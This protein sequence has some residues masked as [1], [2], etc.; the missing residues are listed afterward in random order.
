MPRPVAPRA[1]AAATIALAIAGALCGAIV[2]A[3]TRAHAYEAEID[4]TSAGQAYQLKGASGE[5][6]LSR[7]RVTQ[8]LSLGIYDIGDTARDGQGPQISF[9][10][11]LR[12]DADFGMSIE[13]YALDRTSATARFVP[14]LAP[15]PIDL[16]YGYLEARRLAGGRITARL[17]RQYVVDP[18]GFYSF[19]GALMRLLTPVYVVVEAYGG[20]E[21]RGGLPLSSA[22][23]EQGVQRLDRAGYPSTGYPSYQQAAIA[24]VYAVALESA[25]PTWIH[26][27]LSYRKAWNTGESFVGNNGFLGGPDSLGIYDQRRVSSERLGFGAEAQPL[28]LVDLR[29]SVVYDLYG[30]QLTTIQ[31]GAELTLKKVTV[32]AHYD[33]WRPI[34]DADSIFNVFGIEPMDDVSA[35]VEVEPTD[36]LSLGADATMRRYRSDD[37]AESSRGSIRVATSA[38]YGGGVRARYVWPASRVSFH[39]S[40]LSGDQ[41]LRVG[42]DLAFERVYRQRW[43]VDVRGSAFRFEDKLRVDAAGATRSTTSVGYVLGGG[44]KIDRDTNVQLQ[45]EHDV[46][47][48]VGQRY[49]LLALL[50]VRTWL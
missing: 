41:G 50:N 29:G 44:Y 8:T 19:D 40:A 31:G 3:P 35:R 36:H 22:L 18:L 46:N 45:F 32:G 14:G 21:V 48:L 24:P 34:F 5:P 2:A 25:G 37:T 27:R 9:R 12:M 4:A 17:G 7:R 20:F 47:R 28:G 11:R 49:R 1:R 26:G 43:L 10:A 6:V 23:N 13:E 38:G 15:A 39:G 42:G 33:F 30:R 16:M